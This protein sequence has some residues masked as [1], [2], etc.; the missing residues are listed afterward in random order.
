MLIADCQRNGHETHEYL[1]PKPTRSPKGSLERKIQ[2]LKF[3]VRDYLFYC[4]RHK[5]GRET[6]ITGRGIQGLEVSSSEATFP[7]L[8][9]VKLSTPRERSD[10]P[11]R[12]VLKGAYSDLCQVERLRECSFLL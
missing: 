9:L 6:A 12:D 2:N 11:P 8:G 3:F 4:V 5:R 10:S 1:N 7:V